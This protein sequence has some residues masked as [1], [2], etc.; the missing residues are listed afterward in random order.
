MRLFHG[1]FAGLVLAGFLAIA[2]TAAFAHDGWHEGHYGHL[3]FKKTSRLVVAATRMVHGTSPSVGEFFYR[4]GEL[5]VPLAGRQGYG[6]PRRNGT[7]KPGRGRAFSQRNRGILLHRSI[8]VHASLASGTG[9]R[10][11]ETANPTPSSARM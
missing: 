4:V 2:P 3:G 8:W 7:S 9:S 11:A 1:F 6:L 10:S 5:G